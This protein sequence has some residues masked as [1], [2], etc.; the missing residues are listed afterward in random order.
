MRWEVERYG[1]G[2]RWLREIRHS[3]DRCAQRLDTPGWVPQRYPD[4][5]V[6]LVAVREGV[7]RFLADTDQSVQLAV[8]G[9]AD[10]EPMQRF[11][12]PVG[13]GL[14]DHASSEDQIPALIERESASATTRTPQ[15]S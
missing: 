14:V 1:R 12:G 6:Q 15:A 4:V 9:R 5:A 7:S 8:V 13:E 10:G 2:A 11:A 3:A